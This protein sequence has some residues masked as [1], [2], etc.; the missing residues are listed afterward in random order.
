M[1]SW[2][3]IKT[4]TLSLV[5]F[6]YV[7]LI[8]ARRHHCKIVTFPSSTFF[9]LSLIGYFHY[10][11]NCSYSRVLASPS[12]TCCFASIWG[13][14]HFLHDCPY[15]ERSSCAILSIFFSYFY[16]VWIQDRGVFE[17]MPMVFEIFCNVFISSHVVPVFPKPTNS[18]VFLM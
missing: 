4:P 11:R 16:S 13:I 9:S 15:D 12:F 7:I 17:Q 18:R 1:I 2:S 14:Y 3:T 8:I 5:L 6:H 10:L